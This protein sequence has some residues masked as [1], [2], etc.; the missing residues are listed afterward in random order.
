[1]GSPWK[2]GSKIQGYRKI[3]YLITFFIKTFYL[4]F[5]TFDRFLNN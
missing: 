3:K 2:G 4:N 1:M 5:N